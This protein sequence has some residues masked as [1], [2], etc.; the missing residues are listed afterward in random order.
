V[1]AVSAAEAPIES[2]TTVVIGA[3]LPGLAVASELSRH[4]IPSVVLEGMGRA[5]RRRAGVPDSAAI[6]E[7]SELL[8]LLRGYASS[9]ALDVRHST[10]ARTVKRGGAGSQ[11]VIQTELGVLRADS[12]VI[13]DCPQNQVRRFLRSAGISS[14]LDIVA[15]LKALGIYLVGVTELLAPSTREIIRQ[16]KVVSDSIAGGRLLLA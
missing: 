10:V 14:G 5:P 4:G 7:R 11:W 1:F 13:T 8:R 16:A 15:S 3:G 6:T 12:L 9:H 2:T